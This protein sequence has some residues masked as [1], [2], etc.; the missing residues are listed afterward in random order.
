MP[1]I[2]PAAVGVILLLTGAALIYRLGSLPLGLLDAEAANGLLA[3]DA[4]GHGGAVLAHPGS[5]SALLAGLIALIGRPLGFD[6]LSARLGAVLA[7]LGTILFTSLWL[8][9]VFGS[10]WGIAGGLMLAGL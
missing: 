1:L 2:F 4:S 5:R 9:R 8:R 3:R 6:I 7:G 10:I